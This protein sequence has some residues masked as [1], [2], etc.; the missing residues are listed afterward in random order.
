MTSRSSTLFCVMAKTTSTRPAGPSADVDL[1]QHQAE[2]IITMIA[3][4]AVRTLR[5]GRGTPAP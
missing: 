4:T 1:A 2:V 3:P 5:R